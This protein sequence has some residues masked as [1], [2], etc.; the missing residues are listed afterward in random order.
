MRIPFM[1]QMACYLVLAISIIGVVPK[2]EAGFS[3]SQ[4]VPAINGERAT[5]QARIQNILEQKLVRDRL[6][7]VGLTQDEIN[8]RM[9]RLSD[10]Q[11]HNLALH[12]DQL[13]V[14]GNIV[15]A[16]F[17]VIFVLFVLGVLYYYL[18]GDMTEKPSNQ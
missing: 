3:P 10:Q 8:S 1:K 17:A 11:V 15:T 4:M 2:A 18:G 16:I 13:R 6:E 5:D 12:L 14:G 7:K 9:K